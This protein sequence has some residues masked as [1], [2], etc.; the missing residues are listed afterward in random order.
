MAKNIVFC[1]DGTW[2]G[3]GQ[4]ADDPKDACPS[5]VFK[6]YLSL[7]GQDVLD[8]AT[9]RS[10]NEQ[11]RVLKAPDGRPL[12]VAKYLHGVG[13]S[14]NFLV[15]ALGGAFG[16]GVIARIVRGYTFLSRNHEPGDRIFVVGFSR[17]AYTARALAGLVGAKG[18]IDASKHGG[19]AD[20]AEA[21]RL[22]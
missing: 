16:A 2:N 5:N 3:P 7:A 18:L 8:P 11:E 10:A 1:A 17:G 6:L 20:K 12:Q 15:K 13:D 19:L 14:S 22:D 4:D 21:Y 9:Y